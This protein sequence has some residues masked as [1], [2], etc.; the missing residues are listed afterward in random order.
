M[1]LVSLFAN[2]FPL[3]TLN[4]VLFSV[5]STGC[6]LLCL[7]VCLILSLIMHNCFVLRDISLRMWS[8]IIPDA[9][10]QKFHND[11]LSLKRC[12]SS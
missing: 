5:F 9:M 4:I 6:L 10:Q 3:L 7:I 8:Y 2:M 11:R 1:T 12:N